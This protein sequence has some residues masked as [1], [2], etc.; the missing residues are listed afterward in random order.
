MNMDMAISG[1]AVGFQIAA[2]AVWTTLNGKLERWVWWTIWVGFVVI[3]YHRLSE[4]FHWLGMSHVTALL[5]SV[6]ALAAT[7]ETKYLLQKRAKAKA[8][9]LALQ[10]RLAKLQAEQQKDG[11]SMAAKLAEILVDLKE[12]LQ[13]YEAQAKD[14]GIPPFKKDGE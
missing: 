8:G 1:L 9:M 13:Y 5:F 7:I 2:F 6:F 11:G 10:E 4:T 3:I 12:Q 14:A